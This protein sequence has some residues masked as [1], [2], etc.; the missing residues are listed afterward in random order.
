MVSFINY[1]KYLSSIL[2]FY[3]I[4]LLKLWAKIN[5]PL[6]WSFQVFCYSDREMTNSYIPLC[7]SFFF[8]CSTRTW[9]QGLHLEPFHQCYF[10]EGFFEIGSHRTICPDWL[11]RVILLISTSWVARIRGVS[12]RHLCVILW[13]LFGPFVSWGAEGHVILFIMTNLYPILVY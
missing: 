1:L 10:C 11:G 3:F 4:N 12:H 9:T 5:F 8:F 13:L 6:S 2:Q 7:N